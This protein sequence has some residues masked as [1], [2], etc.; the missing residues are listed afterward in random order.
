MLDLVFSIFLF[1]RWKFPNRRTFES[2]RQV[3]SN[4][5]SAL[6]MPSTVHFPHYLHLHSY[7][8]DFVRL[9]F[10]SFSSSQ[11]GQVPNHRIVYPHWTHPSMS[12]PHQP[13][14]PLE[15]DRQGHTI[16]ITH[17]C[18]FSMTAPTIGGVPCFPIMLLASACFHFWER[19][20]CTCTTS[21]R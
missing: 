6:H 10:D 9:Y 13:H 14:L 19:C 12:H 20:E 21:P 3:P 16:K 8:F 17:H 4:N 15:H 5:E 11:K 18:H 2:Q 1:L 7:H